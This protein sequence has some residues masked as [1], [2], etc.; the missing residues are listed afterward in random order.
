MGGVQAPS[1]SLALRIPSASAVPEGGIWREDKRR[2]LLFF[3]GVLGWLWKR[4]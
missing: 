1:F 4:S 2:V 3:V